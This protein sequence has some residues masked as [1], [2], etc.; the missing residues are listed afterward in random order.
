M[1]IFK[2][3]CAIVFLRLHHPKTISST[4]V[5]DNMLIMINVSYLYKVLFFLSA[6]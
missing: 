6:K 4:H 5:S 1:A 2:P 3:A